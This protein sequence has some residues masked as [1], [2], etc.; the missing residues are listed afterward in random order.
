MF[1]LNDVFVS[2]ASGMNPLMVFV[3]Q[4]SQIAQIYGAAR[5]AC[6][7]RCA[8]P[9]RMIGGVVTRFPLRPPR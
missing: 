7:A 8:T 9:A 6:A 2:L 5:A 4:G 1:Q 3:Q